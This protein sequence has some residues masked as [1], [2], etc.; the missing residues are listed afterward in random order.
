MLISSDIFGSSATVLIFSAI[1]C[2]SATV[3]IASAI[4]GS[5]CL[6]LMFTDIKCGLSENS[7]SKDRFPLDSLMNVMRCEYSEKK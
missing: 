3:L 6:E 7:I 5:S 1:L 4:F 2:S